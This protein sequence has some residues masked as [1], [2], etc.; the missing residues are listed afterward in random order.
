MGRAHRHGWSGVADT[1]S[2]AGPVTASARN[3]GVGCPQGAHEMEVSVK[4]RQV[5]FFVEADDLPS[6]MHTMCDEVIPQFQ[7]LPNFLGLTIIK[8]DLDGRSEVVSTS[9]WDDGLADS[10]HV[11]SH[12]ISEIVRVTGSNPARKVFDIL[13]AS[14]RDTSGELCVE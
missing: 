4:S 3:V 9:Y 6:V 7:E 5:S 2:T 14:V 12:F 1:L 13:Y 10:E 11:S 8:A